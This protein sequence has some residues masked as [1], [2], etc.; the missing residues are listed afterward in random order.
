MSDRIESARMEAKYATALRNLI[1]YDPREGTSL[2][3]T[4]ALDVYTQRA[5]IAMRTREGTATLLKYLADARSKVDEAEEPNRA[6]QI[7]ELAENLAALHEDVNF[8]PL[9]REMV[10]SRTPRP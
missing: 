6:S 4:E 7:D 2:S 9:Y 1:G 3:P 8:E 10:A 5:I